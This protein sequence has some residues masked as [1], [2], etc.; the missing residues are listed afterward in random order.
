MRQ[1]LL[2]RLPTESNCTKSKSYNINNDVSNGA[3]INN[4]IDIRHR[5]NIGNRV[6]D[7]V[8]YADWLSPTN[9]NKTESE[10]YSNHYNIHDKIDEEIL[11]TKEIQP[12]HSNTNRSRNAFYSDNVVDSKRNIGNRLGNKEI[13][14]DDFESSE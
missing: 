13:W 14:L 12:N 2:V 9:P 10:S 1:S 11:F 5:V 6:D 4:R 8:S 3:D 7:E